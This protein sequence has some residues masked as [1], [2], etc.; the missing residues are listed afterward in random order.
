MARFGD[1]GV[2][3]RS[4]LPNAG[5]GAFAWDPTR[6]RTEVQFLLNKNR[7][8][9]LGKDNHLQ[10]EITPSGLKSVRFEICGDENMIIVEKGVHLTNLTINI[11]GSRNR[12]VIGENCFI[13]GWYFSFED[14]NGSLSIGKNTSILG[15]HIVVSE[16]NSKVCIGEDCL[17]SFDIDIRSGDSHSII[18]I[19]TNK[20][21]NHAQNIR[22]DDHVWISA[23][24]QILKGASIGKGSVIGAGAVVTSDIPDH[25][26]AVGVPARVV[27]T[28]VTWLR[29]KI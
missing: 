28:G 17:M 8:K 20:R 27:R 18:D 15:A 29:E 5:L 10:L 9:F 19:Q 16:P 22:I 13:G 23:H 25:S 21:I 1:P 26:I 2:D 24:A 6:L 14:D 7:K 3:R 4:F 12:F 11:K